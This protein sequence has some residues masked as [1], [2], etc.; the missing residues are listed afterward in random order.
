MVELLAAGTFVELL[1]ADMAVAYSS[2]PVAGKS[3]AALAADIVV[4]P[5]PVADMPVAASV[6]Q[7]PE[8]EA[9]NLVALAAEQE[10][11]PV[12]DMPVAASVE[13]E[14]ELEADNLVALAAEQELE[15]V[16]DMPVPSAEPVVELLAAGTS[17]EL[18]VA[19]LLG[20]AVV[21]S[22]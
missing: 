5:V 13:Q 20:Q 16:A 7:E 11:E 4:E 6:E 3:A 2:E 9:D 19:D 8:L 17:V 21:P 10:L 15:P 14:P 18:L 1:V 12:A 22:F